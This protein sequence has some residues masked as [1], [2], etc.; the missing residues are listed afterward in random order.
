VFEESEDDKIDEDSEYRGYA[1]DR[2]SMSSM[3]CV[4]A[5]NNIRKPLDIFNK[6]TTELHHYRV[7]CIIL[8][9]S[10]KFWSSSSFSSSI[11][12]AIVMYNFIARLLANIEIKGFF[13]FYYITILDFTITCSLF[14]EKISTGGKSPQDEFHN[15]HPRD[16]FV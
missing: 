4:A 7:L 2:P 5:A 11:S 13:Y 9:S 15:F 3:R 16:S 12:L 1:L 6:Y 10:I 8:L 14:L